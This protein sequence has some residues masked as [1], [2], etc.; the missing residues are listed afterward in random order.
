[1]TDGCL[2]R[3]QE[4]GVALA[5]F[6]PWWCHSLKLGE[7]GGGASMSIHTVLVKVQVLCGSLEKPPGIHLLA[8]LLVVSSDYIT[9]LVRLA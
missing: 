6:G 1:M 7:A 4:T 9:Y 5:H 3:F 2:W 8:T